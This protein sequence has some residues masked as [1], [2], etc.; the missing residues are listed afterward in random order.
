[1]KRLFFLLLSLSLAAGE[2]SFLGGFM[3]K[4]DKNFKEIYGK[5]GNFWG[6][7]AQW[8]VKAFFPYLSYERFER[9]G[10][11]LFFKEPAK[12]VHQYLGAGLS[13]KKNLKGK[14]WGILGAGFVYIVYEEEALGEKIRD[15][16]PGAEAALGFRYYLGKFFLGVY[17]GY[18]WGKDKIGREKINFNGPKGYL[19]AGIIF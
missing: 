9:E 2:I 1:M 8:K 5:G 17:G 13:F 19:E 18:I 12:T 7:K 16:C 11:T 14:L 6:I 3:G 4:E 15:E 10:K